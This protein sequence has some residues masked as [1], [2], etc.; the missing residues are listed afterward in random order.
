MREFKLK[1]LDMILADRGKYIAACLT[2]VR[3]HQQAGYPGLL[4]PLASYDKW[5]AMV[6]SALVWLGKADPVLTME[7]TRA[8]DPELSALRNVVGGWHATG[9]SSTP[10]TVA[11]IITLSATKRVEVIVR[12]DGY[13]ETVETDEPKYP[14][15]NDALMTVA[16]GAKGIDRRALGRW[17]DRQKN[18]VIDAMKITGKVDSHLKIARWTLLKVEKVR[19]ID[20]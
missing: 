10:R 4:A 3:A 16:G 17:L 15:F 13:S 1:P 18:R 2:I 20:E 8:E 19:I 14:E 9:G 11:E 5:S 7:T 6:R 12:S